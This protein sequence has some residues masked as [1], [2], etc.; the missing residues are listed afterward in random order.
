MKPMPIS[1][2]RSASSNARV[3]VP[4]RLTSKTLITSVLSE[5]SKQRMCDNCNQTVGL[6]FIGLRTS[7]ISG[8]STF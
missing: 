4:T 7:G 2:P 6:S 5:L 1:D 8:G 3:I